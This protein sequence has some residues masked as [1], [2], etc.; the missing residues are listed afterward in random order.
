MDHAQRGLAERIGTFWL[1][2]G[3]LGGA[4]LAAGALGLYN[5]QPGMIDETAPTLLF[6]SILF[7]AAVIASTEARIRADRRQRT[8]LEFPPVEGASG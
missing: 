2:F 6:L 7:L 1:V 4:A 8:A 3:G 5:F